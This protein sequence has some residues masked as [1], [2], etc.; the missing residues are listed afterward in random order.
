MRKQQLGM[1]GRGWREAKTLMETLL[2]EDGRSDEAVLAAIRG[3]YALTYS[4]E[5][6]TSTMRGNPCTCV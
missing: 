3:R 1:L 6:S 4:S 2:L 5:P